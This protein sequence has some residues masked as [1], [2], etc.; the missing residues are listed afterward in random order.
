MSLLTSSNPRLYIDGILLAGM[1][2]MS[3]ALRHIQLSKYGTPVNFFFLAGATFLSCEHSGMS[4][5]FVFS[6]ADERLFIHR[7]SCGGRWL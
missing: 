1:M 3:Q 6:M 5:S 4:C 7:K 2:V